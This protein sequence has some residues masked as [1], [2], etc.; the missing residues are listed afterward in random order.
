M[1]TFLWKGNS[2]TGYA[3]VAWN[4]VCLPDEGGLGIRDVQALNYALM[5]K[6]LWAVINNH[7]SFI[8]VQWVRQNHIRHK[9][10]WTVNTNAGSWCWRKLLRLR[11]IL[12]SQ[13][14]YRNSYVLIWE[15]PW[16]TLGSLIHL[17]SSG[18]QLTSTSIVDTMSMVILN[19]VWFW[20]LIT[21]AE[22]LQISQSLPTLHGG[23]DTIVWKSE[24][25]TFTTKA[26]YRLF[27][28]PKSKVDW[29]SLLVGSF[30]IPRNTFILWLAILGR[31]STMDKPW[32]SHLDGGC[33]LCTDG[34]ERNRRKFQQI[35]RP[36]ISLVTI[37]LNECG[38]RILS[39]ELSC[40]LSTIALYRLWR[41]P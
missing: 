9:T 26:V 3:K 7:D 40:N 37:I 38:Q 15:D 2:D 8:W 31:L 25:G 29:S 10:V 35:E 23:M 30:T 32:L 19:G 28:P 27:H 34:Q 24:R 13:V 18:P 22:C 33:S 21:D 11:A 17:L 41:I 4:Q 39:A 14:E 12:Q 6:H 20:P 5:S 1:R 16:H 36:A